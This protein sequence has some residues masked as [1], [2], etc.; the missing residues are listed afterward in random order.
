MKCDA[1]HTWMSA[2]VVVTEHPYASVT[3]NRGSCTLD[4]VP[5]GKY[6]LGAWHETLGEQTRE[7]EVSAGD[8]VAVTFKFRVSE[9]ARS[10]GQHQEK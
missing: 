8:T 1:G 3:D 4:D 5:P 10:M 9:A 2:Y 7:I 6:T